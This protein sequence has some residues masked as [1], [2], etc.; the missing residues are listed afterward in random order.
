M[1]SSADS[2]RIQSSSFSAPSGSRPS[3]PAAATWNTTGA[4]VCAIAS[5]MPKSSSSAA[6]VPGTGS[7][8]RV[9]W[10]FT[11][12]VEKPSAPASTASRASLAMASIVGP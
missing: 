9:T 5:A 4:P 7:P 2:R 12:E 6:N 10:A 1:S 11:R 3:A 8:A